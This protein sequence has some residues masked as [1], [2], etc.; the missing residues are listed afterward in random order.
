MRDFFGRGLQL[1]FAYGVLVLQITA[2]E[3]SLATKHVDAGVE[4]VT[5]SRGL[6]IRTSKPL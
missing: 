1:H 2:L 3:R 6:A 5:F 4:V